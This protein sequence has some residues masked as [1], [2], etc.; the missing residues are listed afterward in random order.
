MSV[1]I[2]AHQLGRLIDRTIDHIGDDQVPALHGIRLEADTTH[3]YAIA[4]D[5]H[6]L[7][8]ARYRHHGLDGESFARTIPADALPALR[9]WI[10]TLPGRDPVTMTAD[11]DRL[12][13]T[14]PRSDLGIM[15]DPARAFFDWRGV[16]RGVTEQTT[17]TGTETVFPALNTRFQARFRAAGTVV[18]V[19][20]TADQQAVLVVGEDFLGAQMPI[21]ARCD[22]FGT[23]NLATLEDVRASWQHTLSAS[24]AAM[25]D[26]IPAPPDG[27]GYEVT[28]DIGETAVELLKLTLRSTK[29]LL[30]AST[31]SD[32]AFAAYATAGVTAWTAYRY[33]DAL[34]T[35][36]PKLAAA[37]VAETADQLESG[38]IGEFAWD[39][40]ETAGHDPQQWQEEFEERQVREQAAP[41]GPSR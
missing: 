36:D 7:A 27:P 22:G 20:A 8:T 25:P 12:R 26:A 30:A 41:A 24:A 19:R 29:E 6:T 35:A 39:A 1:T 34:H 40:A 4:S 15:V 5:R 18:R 33:L 32:E 21:R 3:L 11:D 17:D 2:N 16:L 13:F 9:E 31:A 14:A 38:E 37:V 10:N 28:K 23:D